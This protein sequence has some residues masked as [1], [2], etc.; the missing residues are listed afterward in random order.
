MFV[1][2][3][4]KQHAFLVDPLGFSCDFL[5]T[6]T[7][8]FLDTQKGELKPRKGLEIWLPHRNFDFLRGPF[9]VIP[10]FERRKGSR[11]SRP[12]FMENLRFTTNQLLKSVKQ[13]FQVTARLIEDQTEI[14]GLTTIDDEQPTWRSTTLPCDKAVEITNAKT[15]VFSYSV[16]C[17]GGISD[18]PVEARKNKIKWH[19]ANRYL[20]DLNRIDGEPTQFEYKI[21]PGFTTLRVLEEVMTDLQCEPEQFKGRII[22]MSVY[23][24]IDLTRRGNQEKCMMNFVTVANYARRLPRGRWSFLGPGSEKKWYGTYSDKP[25]GDWDKT[26]ERMMLNLAESGH[27]IFCATSALERAKNFKAKEMVRSLFTLTVVKKPLN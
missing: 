19:L 21:F 14:S 23:N 3:C 22:F 7:L 17:L 16:L 4:L 13:F 27:S 26:A 9:Q 24:D 6:P 1:K 20:K 5:H 25:C 11:A 18:Q 12:P 10:S 15:Y 8:M 2:P